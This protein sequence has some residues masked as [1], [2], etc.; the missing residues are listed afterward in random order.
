MLAPVTLK[1]PPI[2]M[3]I[4][5]LIVTFVAPLIVMPLQYVPGF[6]VVEPVVTLKLV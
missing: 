5:G 6:N 3:Y 4:P 2:R 1:P